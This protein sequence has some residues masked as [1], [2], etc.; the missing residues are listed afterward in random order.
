MNSKEIARLAA[1][2]TRAIRDTITDSGRELDAA[3]KT[4]S[5]NTFRLP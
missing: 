2:T 4:S 1:W 3:A 5:A